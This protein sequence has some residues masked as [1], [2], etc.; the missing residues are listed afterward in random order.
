MPAWL[1]SQYHHQSEGERKDAHITMNSLLWEPS[2]SDGRL[3]LTCPV[4][5]SNRGFGVIQ[6]IGDHLKCGWYTFMLKKTWYYVQQEGGR[7]ET[8]DM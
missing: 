4:Y 3:P 6:G 2:V 1:I 5:F 7:K 8:S